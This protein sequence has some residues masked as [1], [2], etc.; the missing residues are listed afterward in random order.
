MVTTELEMDIAS[1][2][3]ICL[4]DSDTPMVSIYDHDEENR[5]VSICD[6]IEHCTGIKVNLLKSFCSKYKFAGGF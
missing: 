2:C 1:V 5:A 6:K 3:R 4:Q